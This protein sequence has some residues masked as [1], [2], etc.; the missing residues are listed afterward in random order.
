MKRER[1]SEAIV[2]WKIVKWNMVKYVRI[3]KADWQCCWVAW[4]WDW[5]R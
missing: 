5:V 2:S 3:I 1:E 4:G